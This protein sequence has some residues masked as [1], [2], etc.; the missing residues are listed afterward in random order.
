MKPIIVD[1]PDRMLFPCDVH[2]FPDAVQNAWRLSAAQLEADVLGR[3][4]R[5]APFKEAFSCGKVLASFVKTWN[6]EQ[7][8]PGYPAVDIAAELVQHQAM[9][10]SPQ[11][12]EATQLLNNKMKFAHIYGF[13]QT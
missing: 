5:I 11:K 2:L 6:D 12:T 8:R 10:R 4:A 9:G 1:N 13:Q 7:R 3:L